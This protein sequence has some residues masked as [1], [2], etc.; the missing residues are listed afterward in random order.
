VR[1]NVVH[2]NG[3]PLNAE[4]DK[5][6][7]YGATV[8]GLGYCTMEEVKYNEK[9]ESMANTPS[10][11]KI[12]TMSDVC[13]N[14]VVKQVNKER[15][16]ASVLGSKAVGEPP[17][18]YGLAGWFSIMNALSFITDSPENIDLKMPATPEAVLLAIEDIKKKR[19]LNV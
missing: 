4:I 11:Y 7:I 13:S 3:I 18:L 16:K 6:Q 17:F 9:G 5:G 12:P 1:K 19:G 14:F 8:Q 10:T 2:D 15:S